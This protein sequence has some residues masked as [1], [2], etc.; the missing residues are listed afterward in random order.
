MQNTLESSHIRRWAIVGSLTSCVGT[1]LS[2]VFIIGILLPEI[3]EEMGLSPLA[4]GMLGSSVLISNL[5]FCIPANLITSRFR[6]WRMVTLLFLGVGG[7]A[8]LQSWSPVL[9]ALFVGRVGAGLFFTSTQS[10]R[11]LLIQQWIPRHRISFTNGLSFAGIDLI[12]GVAFLVTPQFQALAGGW[13]ETFFIWSMISFG[14]TIVWMIVGGER[15]TEEYAERARSETTSPINA[16]RNYKQLWIMGMGIGGAMAAQAGFQNFW[17]TLAEGELGLSPG[18]TGLALGAT[19]FAAAPTDFLANAIPTLV[20]RRTLVL[21]VCGVLSIIT[22]TGMVYATSSLVVLALAV[23]KG[24]SFAFFPVLMIMVFHI[25]GIKPRE[26]GIGMSFMETSI[27]GGSAIGPILVGGLQEITDDL[28][29]ALFLSGFLPVS[30]LVAAVWLSLRDRATAPPLAGAPI[31]LPT[32]QAA[33]SPTRDPT[34]RLSTRK[35]K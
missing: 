27:W 25:P 11:A 31:E 26:I 16:L 6:P 10:P 13:R 5:I 9:A 19:T 33:I 14:L 23:T 17:P 21:I 20:R 30:L 12:M 7:S 32:A 35:S 34:L 29:T 22:L 15:V 1:S 4:Q 2:I 8:L 28:Q 24:F 3:S 18:F